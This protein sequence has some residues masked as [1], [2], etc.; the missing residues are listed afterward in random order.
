MKR[1]QTPLLIML[2]GALVLV[3]TSGV[4]G[5]FGLFLVPM[6]DAFGWGR[7]PFALAAALST[8]LMGAASP[9]LGAL[10]D[11]YGTGR[12]IV[13]GALLWVFGLI[14]MAYSASPLQLVVSVGL[15]VGL[16]TAATGISVAVGAVT[17]SVP[18]EL[19]GRAAG[20]VTAGAAAGQA[21]L[22]PV[23]YGLIALLDWQLALLSLSLVMALM[24]PAAL[25]LSGGGRQVAGEPDTS[26]AWRA[27]GEAM[28]HRG[29]WLLTVGFFVCGVH[30]GFIVVHLPAQ[31]VDLGLSSAIG[32]T[33]LFLVNLANI[34]GSYTWGHWGGMRR[35][36]YLLSTLYLL[37]TGVLV[38]FVLVPATPL[39]VSL[40][41]VAL[42]LVWF[43]TV[44]LTSGVV[45]EIFGMRHL[46][47]LFGFVFFGHQLG[48]F[49]GSFMGGVVYDATQ[50]YTIMWVVNI[51]LGIL[52][53][54][55][56]LP[57]NDQ[58]LERLA[59][60]PAAAG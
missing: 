20:V 52:T 16:A 11:R 53:T 45:G 56:H 4:R 19:R 8:L 41:S 39:S 18:E 3:L 13:S 57:I 42:G 25:G 28:R 47:M 21:V 30:Y 17:R 29:F 31:L 15:L 22:V 5:S 23:A 34:V 1:W 32:A 40:L 12:V 54:A 24:I 26:T 37:R 35:K 55:I 59:P 14:G 36:K 46:S 9:V 2:A 38:L 58:R 50:S 44:P 51:A 10:S 6:T 27:F 49:I 60:A 33:A 48:A 43:G 7:S